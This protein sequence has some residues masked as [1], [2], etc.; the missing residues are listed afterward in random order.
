MYKFPE[1]NFEL[2]IFT[3]NRL[4]EIW[5]F[6]YGCNIS[7]SDKEHIEGF[8]SYMISQIRRKKTIKENNK[9]VVHKYPY[10][11]YKLFIE[12]DCRKYTYFRNY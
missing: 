12:E 7:E 5:I 8:I 1:N 11:G 3:N 10:A 4:N 2:K 9:I 6:L